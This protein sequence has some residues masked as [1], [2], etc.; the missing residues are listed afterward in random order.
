MIRRAVSTQ[1]GSAAPCSPCRSPVELHIGKG[2]L[3][4]PERR[5]I[6]Q[7]ERFGSKLQR[8]PLAK[9]IGAEQREIDIL[10]RIGPQNVPAGAAEGKLARGN[11]RALIE[12]GL[13]ARVIEV[14]VPDHIWPGASGVVNRP[15]IGDVYVHLD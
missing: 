10:K 1:T 11:E 15:N 4:D 5:M 8:Q 12:P 13:R 2:S 7:I 14:R 9:L 3:R 6:Q